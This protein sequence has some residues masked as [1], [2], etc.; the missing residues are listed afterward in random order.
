LEQQQF[1]FNSVRENRSI[2]E[3]VKTV[4]RLAREELFKEEHVKLS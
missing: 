2:A 3:F 1:D 4:I